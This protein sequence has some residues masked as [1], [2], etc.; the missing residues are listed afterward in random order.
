ME[1]IH[2]GFLIEYYNGHLPYSALEYKKVQWL[3]ASII[4]LATRR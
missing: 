4:L 1:K 3:G 2:V